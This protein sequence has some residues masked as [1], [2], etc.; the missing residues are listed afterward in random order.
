LQ[1]QTPP[2]ALRERILQVQVMVGLRQFIP[3]GKTNRVRLPGRQV[4]VAGIAEIGV[5]KPKEIIEPAG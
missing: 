1:F 4:T 5:E 3:A 2:Q